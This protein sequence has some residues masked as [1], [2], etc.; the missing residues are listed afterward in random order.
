[1]KTKRI[2]ARLDVKNDALVKGIHLEGLR[3]L[4]APDSFAELYYNEGVDELIYMD[5]VASLYNRNGLSDFVKRTA[6]K[7]FIPLSV[8]GGIRTIDDV[9]ELL[10]SGAD[11]VIINTAAVRNPQLITELAQK[12][13]SSTIVVAIEAIKDN[14]SQYGVYIDNG[15]EYTGK[16]VAAWARTVEMLGAGEIMLTSVDKE[17]TGKGLDYNLIELVKKSVS[18]PV[19][20]HGGISSVS[21]IKEAL[22]D[23]RID[24]IC[25]SSV[26]HYEAVGRAEFK[27]EDVSGNK[28]FLKSGNQK[29]NLEPVSVVD[30]KS[31]LKMHGVRVR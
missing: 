16:E 8:G 5:V 24:A 25:A 21:D 26:F 29:K 14:D 1:M 15:R 30:C 12:F 10:N 28:S 4:G 23:E 27:H 13:G 9:R 11:K 19:I 6:N 18:I 31:Y 2:I 22:D 17:G 7:I 3:V 20:A